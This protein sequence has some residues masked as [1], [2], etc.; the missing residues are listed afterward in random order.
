MRLTAQNISV[1]LGSRFV[2]HDVWLDVTP[3]E[4]LAVAGP[5]GAGKSTLLKALAGLLPVQD[6]RVLLDNAARPDCALAATG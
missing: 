1:S 4:I 3:G 6:G 2:L 5:N